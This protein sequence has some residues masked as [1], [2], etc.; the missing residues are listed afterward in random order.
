[1]I[2]TITTEIIINAPPEAVWKVLTDFRRYED[3]NPFIRSMEGMAKAGE[4]IKIIMQ[5][6]NQRTFHFSAKIVNAEFPR[7]L[8]WKGNLLM[9]GIFEGYHCF[10]LE[11]YNESSTRLVHS[12]EFSGILMPLLWWRFKTSIKV[13]FTWMNNSL[14]TIAESDYSSR[15]IQQGINV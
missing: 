13:G 1:M 5:P 12:E 8:C 7:V 15:K 9:R 11:L 14:S 4:R 10:K 6:P 2:K 3:W